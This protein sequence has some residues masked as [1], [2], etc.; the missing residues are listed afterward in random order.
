[1]KSMI[2]VDD[3]LENI[4][5]ETKF[6][7]PENIDLLSSLNR[8]LAE[9]IYSRDNLPPFNKSAMDGYAIKSQE[10]II[11]TK[12]SPSQF[13]VQGVIKAGDYYSGRLE[14]GQ[15]LKIM[16]GAPLPAGA[17]AVLEIEKIEK[18]DN[19]I[20]I[21]QKV[22]PGT[23]I[24][25]L[26]EEI[27]EGQ[28]ALSKG[29][30]IRPAEIGLLASLG[31]KSIK[32]YGRPKVALLITGDELINIEEQLTR[33]KIR[34]SNEYSLHAL[35]I[36]A[37]AEA[38][39]FGIIPDNIDILREKL[40][41]AFEQADLVISTGGVSAGDYDFIKDVLVQIGAQI[42]FS[43]VAIKPGKPLTFATYNGKTF[44]GL[45]GNPSAV[46]N[47]FEQFVKPAIQKMMGRDS[48]LTEEF[49]VVLLEDFKAKKGR[50]H[51]VYASI[52]KENGIY[53]ACNAGSQS[54]SQ[55]I[56]MSKSNGVVIIPEDKG[57][58]QAGETLQ[59]RFLFH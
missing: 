9:N 22:E 15:A 46:I 29:Q 45:P 38:I 40:R 51:Y 11:A 25:K 54:S 10:T 50:R 23:N 3:A 19:Q 53:Y 41:L 56:T 17:D 43:S 58:V 31:Y 27:S 5:K 37:G 12:D 49:S 33:G 48:G 21:Y 47:T 52:K 34:N 13:L 42:K 24:I 28:L 26:G 44:W 2:K 35:V 6:L 20:F 30:I 59:A 55:L 4:L 39:S 18:K 8:V 36:G 7:E 32:V 1:M 14:R 57:P 16:T